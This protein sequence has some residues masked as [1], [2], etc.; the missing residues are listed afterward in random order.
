M[1]STKQTNRSWLLHFRRLGMLEAD[2]IGVGTVFLN[3]WSGAHVLHPGVPTNAAILKKA[4]SP[5]LPPAD[6]VFVG[7][8]NVG[9]GQMAL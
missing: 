7:S 3:V 8:K 4:F 2:P 6:K 9:N 5:S 1:E